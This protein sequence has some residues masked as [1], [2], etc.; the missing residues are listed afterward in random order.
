M[1]SLGS[2]TRCCTVSLCLILLDPMNVT[3]A[4]AHQ[5]RSSL[6]MLRNAIERCPEDF[7]LAGNPNRF[8]HIAYH[9]LFYTHFYL[10]PTDA[11]FVPWPLHRPEYNYLGEVPLKPGYKPLIDRPYSQS[12]LLQYLE[13]CLE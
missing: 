4:A 6:S 9:A 11:D 12:E 10:A 1:F 13:F 3:E 7:W 5:Y 2:Y 8:W